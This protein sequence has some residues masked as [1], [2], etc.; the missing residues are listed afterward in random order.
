MK[1]STHTTILFFT[2]RKRK[3]EV[4]EDE[5]EDGVSEMNSNDH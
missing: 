4:D 1:L 5:D 2:Y 3:E